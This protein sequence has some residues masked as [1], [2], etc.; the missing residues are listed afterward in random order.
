L[1]LENP[2]EKNGPDMA[3]AVLTAAVGKIS[4][5]KNSV[6]VRTQRATQA[7]AAAQVVWAE[8]EVHVKK[9]SLINPRAGGMDSLK[10]NVPGFA[11]MFALFSLVWGSMSIVGERERG[12]FARL[13]SSPLGKVDIL[14]GKLLIMFSIACMQLTVFFGF[15]H[16]VFGMDLGHSLLGLVLLSM[17]LALTA[18]SLGVLL[19]SLAKTQTQLGAISSILILGM[20]ALGGSWWPAEMMPDFMQTLAHFVT[21]NAWAMDGYKN[22]LWYGGGLTS[23]LPQIG[24]LGGLA[25]VAF[26]IGVATFKFE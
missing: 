2:L 19:G 25:V 11:I 22:L 6:P 3:A 14:L 20:S 13:L 8:P 16:F 5:A 9:E 10:Q 21:I 12:T 15:G 4:Q 18:T 24:M 17:T 1:L 7:S 26:G 23:V